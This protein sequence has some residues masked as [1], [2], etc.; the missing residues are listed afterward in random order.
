[1][2]LS[3]VTNSRGSILVT[4]LESFS[5]LTRSTSDDSQNK[6]HGSRFYRCVQCLNSLARDNGP[7]WLLSDVI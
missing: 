1:M 7:I 5:T 6:Q 3:A 2:E 4:V